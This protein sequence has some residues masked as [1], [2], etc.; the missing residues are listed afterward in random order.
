MDIHAI[1]NKCV[2]SMIR[3]GFSGKPKEL[4]SMANVFLAKEIG[5]ESGG[6]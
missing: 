3:T 4:K 1:A 5:F 2:N 6:S